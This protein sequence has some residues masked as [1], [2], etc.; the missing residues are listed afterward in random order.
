MFNLFLHKVQHVVIGFAL[1]VATIFGYTP[2]SDLVYPI[3]SPQEIPAQP[4]IAIQTDAEKQRI[5]DLQKTV[6]ELQK[7]LLLLEQNQE[8]GAT[9]AIP[10]AVAFFNSS[11]LS[12]ISTTANSMTLVS[13]T[14]NNGA[15]TLAS[16]TY[17][18]TIDE[19]TAVEEMVIADCTSVTCTNMTRGLDRL[20][21]TTTVTGL[22]YAHRRGASVKITDGPQLLIL[23]R[24]LN[25]IATVPSLLTYTSGTACNSASPNSTICDKAYTD[26]V[27]V[28]GA[29]NAND[30]TK[31]IVETATA[32][33]A[34]A[35][36][37]LGAT[38][39]R[40]V[41]GANIAT[42][43]CQSAANSVLVASSTTGKLGGNCLDG[44]YSYT[45]SG[46]NTLSGTNIF[47][48]STTFAA[49]TTIAASSATNNALVL[50]GLKYAFP[51]SQ[52]AVPTVLT[53]SG[54]G[55]LSWVTGAPR[56][57]AMN[58]TDFSASPGTYATSTE[59][60]VIPVNTLNASSTIKVR[61]YGDCSTSGGGTCT[62]YLKTSAG[63][64]L[65]SQ[66][67]VAIGSANTDIFSLDFQTFANNSNSAQKSLAIG[68][69]KNI[70]GGTVN[71]LS[72]ENTTS[73]DFTQAMTLTLV[74]QATASSQADIFSY[75][76]EVNP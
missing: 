35:G 42:S 13:A 65:I 74:V 26:G 21:G 38:G 12:P 60:L 70:N 1:S 63:A 33:E 20:T 45:L 7:Q 66:A 2:T 67:V 24:I 6:F 48:A 75:L 17:A 19:G 44:A 54:S 8:L 62:A 10:T 31:G 52:A 71:V 4:E 59:S 14:Y 61:V 56:Y 5:V 18:F 25:G 11:L 53:N 72:T 16:S 40:L 30:T 51:S 39:A 43:T 69:Q 64:T 23:S 37:S 47:T 76:I 27:A 15:S 73:L 49:T 57:T 50:N 36:T 58:F 55:N 41:L 68:T 29:S 22:G 3:P 34:A 32:A 46:N 9:N 28:A